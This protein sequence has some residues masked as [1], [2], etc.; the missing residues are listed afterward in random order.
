MGPKI[1]AAVAFI[2]ARGKQAAI[3]SIEQIEAA[4]GGS[5][6]TQFG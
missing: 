2:E 5:A 1:E 4:V 6:G 3:C